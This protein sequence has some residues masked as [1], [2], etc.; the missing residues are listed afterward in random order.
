MSKIWYDHL[1]ILEE[2]EVEL[3]NLNLEAEEKEELNHLIDEMVHHRV[4]DRVLR[5]LP[6]HHHA[7]F[8]IEFKKRPH[9]PALVDYID[10]KIDESV[11]RHIKEEIKILKEELLED[12][13]T[14]SKR[15]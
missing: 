1:I 3:N 13:T 8:L 11:E 10:E 9:D 6:R 14:K 4:M 15:K 7:N 12:L 5:V 2:V